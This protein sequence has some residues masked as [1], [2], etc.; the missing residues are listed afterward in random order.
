MRLPVRWRIRTLLL[1]VL[2]VGCCTS[3]VALRQRADRHRRIALEYTEWKEKLSQIIAVLD[4]TIR[5]DRKSIAQTERE[6]RI[7]SS[8][9]TDGIGSASSRLEQRLA[10][11]SRVQEL[12][13][14]VRQQERD[15]SEAASHPLESGS[16]R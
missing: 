6:I 15:Y 16:R 4:A 7:L 10:I 14:Y 5:R 11:R 1:A 13:E 2:L 8:S 3:V 9:G 12:R